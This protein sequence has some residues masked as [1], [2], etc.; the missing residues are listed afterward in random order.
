MNLLELP[1]AYLI[2]AWML[3]RIRNQEAAMSAPSLNE[4]PWENSL[5]VYYAVSEILK[6]GMPR[7]SKLG[8]RIYD[9]LDKYAKKLMQDIRLADEMRIIA[10]GFIPKDNNQE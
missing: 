7:K 4:A 5:T 6:L 1:L 9:K 8:C 10:V 3:K 2:M